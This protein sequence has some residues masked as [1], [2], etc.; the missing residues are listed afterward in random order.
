MNHHSASSSRRRLWRL[1]VLVL[2]A[3]SLLPEIVVY[4]LTALAKINGCEISQETA[5]KICRVSLSGLIARALTP[6]IWIASSAFPVGFLASCYVAITFG[7][8][9]LISRLS[10]GLIVT[11]VF[12][13]LYFPVVAIAH[14]IDLK[15]CKPN[16][17]VIFGG[18]VGG[19][20]Y[21]VGQNDFWTVVFFALLAFCAYAVLAIFIRL[22][23]VRR[24]TG[25]SQ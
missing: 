16:H 17:C 11:C 20:A 12:G 23:W 22:L 24:P 25:S 14:L 7:W 3:V 6:E 2:V 4:F 8:R 5:C 21:G 1:A 15:K 18:D 13:V 9:H 19:T 10:L